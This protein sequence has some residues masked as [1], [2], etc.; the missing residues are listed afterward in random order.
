MVKTKTALAKT[1]KSKPI[2]SK[3]LEQLVDICAQGFKK[4]EDA[5][6]DTFVQGRKEGFTDQQ[7]GGMIRNR[8]LAVGFNIRTVQRVLPKSAKRR[9]DRFFSVEHDKMSGSAEEEHSTTET[10]QLDEDSVIYQM[11]ADKYVIEDLELYDKAYLI[12]LVLYLDS[13]IEELGGK[14]IGKKTKQKGAWY[15]YIREEIKRQ[16]AEIEMKS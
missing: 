6:N 16:D 8:M 13:K 2:A 14:K 15:D 1:S 3:K 4:I 10:S 7:I 11:P 12:K 5:V 9:N